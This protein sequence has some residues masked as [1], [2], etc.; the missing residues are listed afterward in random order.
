L[1]IRG[2]CASTRGG[3]VKRLGTLHSYHYHS[4]EKP[5]NFPVVS[6]TMV[7]FRTYL[8]CLEQRIHTFYKR[9]VQLALG[10]R[11]GGSIF[12]DT[13]LSLIGTV[14]QFGPDYPQANIALATAMSLCCRRW[15]NSPRRSG[16]SSCSCVY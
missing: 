10:N 9:L 16:Q 13:W 3:I 8:H 15:Q 6:H 12:P 7:S 14:A 5:K 1:K 4:L 11:K 2:G